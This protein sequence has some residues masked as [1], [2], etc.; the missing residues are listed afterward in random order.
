VKLSLVFV[1]FQILSLVIPK[2][3]VFKFEEMFEL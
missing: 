1:F 3:K 2:F